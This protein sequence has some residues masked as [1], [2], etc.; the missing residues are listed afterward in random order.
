MLL[1]NLIKNIPANINNIEISNLASDSRKVKKGCLFFALQ[2][3]KL[4]GNNFITQA[5]KK[6]AKAIV[7][8]RKIKTNCRCSKSILYDAIRRKI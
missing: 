4:D 1:K 6:G 5:V 3:S 7:C 2:G 8:S